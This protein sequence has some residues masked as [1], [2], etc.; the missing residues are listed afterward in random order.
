MDLLDRPVMI[1]FQELA[2][3]IQIFLGTMRIVYFLKFFLKS[4]KL[5]LKDFQ[6]IYN[7]L[8]D[9]GVYRVGG[10]NGDSVIKK[11]LENYYEWLIVFT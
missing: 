3:Q 5:N 9:S 4:Q 1:Y 7:C 6:S 10:P 11:F 2:D 8:K